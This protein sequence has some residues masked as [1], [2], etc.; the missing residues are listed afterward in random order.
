[1]K[2]G[3]EKVKKDTADLVEREVKVVRDEINEIK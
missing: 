1:M 3:L 2:S